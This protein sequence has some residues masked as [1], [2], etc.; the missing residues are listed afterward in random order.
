MHVIKIKE[1]KREALKDMK[2]KH[3][4]IGKGMRKIITRGH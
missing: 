2:P 1:R 4:Q 3:K